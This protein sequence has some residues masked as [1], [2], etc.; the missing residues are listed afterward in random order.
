[1]NRSIRN[2]LILTYLGI[3]L[4]TALLIF[5][6]IRTTS[7][8]RLRTL[9][10]EQTVESLRADA[11]IWYVARGNWA[12]F[13][14]AMGRN[15]PPPPL[16]P[17]LPA[18]SG[19]S[20]PPPKLDNVRRPPPN[21]RSAND[22]QTH[23]IALL[24]AEY[25]AVLPMMDSPVGAVVPVEVRETLIPLEIDQQVVGYMMVPD[26]PRLVDLS[27]SE[28]VY[29]RRTNE[30]VLLA[31]AGAVVVSLLMGWGLAG[32]LIRPIQDLT[33]A[34]R[35]LA[36]GDP[37]PLVPIRS[38]DELGELTTTFNQMSADLAEARR[39]RRQMT[40]DIA[41]DLGT[42]IQVISGYIEAMQDG[43]LSLTPSRLDI[44]NTE[45]DH[46]RRL[47]HDLDTLSQ[48]DN[49]NIRLDMEK[50]DTVDFLQHVEQSFAPLVSA[51]SIQ[52]E[53]VFPTTLPPIYA[54]RRRLLQVMGNLLSNALRYTSAG[55]NITIAARVEQTQ[56]FVQVQDTGSGISA[57]DLPHIFK[58]FY[59]ADASRTDSGKM[60]LGLAISKALVEAMGGEI[61]AEAD[62]AQGATFRIALKRA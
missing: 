49:R 20:W 31:S 38:Q 26:D 30:V 61:S 9:V 62:P 44:I 8:R 10:L 5:A 12:G 25:R 52:L 51:E 33:D 32:V 43:S 15:Q 3:A 56:V 29:L 36:K 50:I 47:V 57:A 17:P 58:R 21:G 54:D 24:D 22:P 1:M 40:A 28:Q 34:S 53:A 42:P 41:H 2:K 13:D 27:L 59:Q 19:S 4:L 39:Q 11:T 46:L 48:A 37:A 14:R 60:G 55:G 23:P 16:P 45:I 18:R 6:L 35:A 7:S